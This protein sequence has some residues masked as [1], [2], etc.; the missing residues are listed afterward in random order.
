MSKKMLKVVIVLVA[1]LLVGQLGAIGVKAGD[2]GPITNAIQY[3]NSCP[4]AFQVSLSREGKTIIVNK[5]V[6]WNG[7]TY[8]V[9]SQ[10]GVEKVLV[11]DKKGNVYVPINNGQAYYYTDQNNIQ[12]FLPGT[13]K[14]SEPTG[15]IAGLTIIGDLLDDLQKAG[16]EKVYS[17]KSVNLATGLIILDQKDKYGNYLQFNVGNKVTSFYGENS[18]K[19]TLAK[20]VGV[21][22]E[23]NTLVTNTTA[24]GDARGQGLITGNLFVTGLP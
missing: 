10:V 24:T 5:K 19:L 20:C 17:I 2:Q 11:M 16:G 9:V 13:G 15:Q 7:I 23:N 8:Y 3:L 6:A 22:V 18:I 4:S 14:P 1:F 12:H 21:F